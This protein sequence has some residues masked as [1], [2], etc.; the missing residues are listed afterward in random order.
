MIQLMKK[1]KKRKKSVIKQIGEQIEK[2]SLNY[3]KRMEKK[4]R[5]Y[6]MKLLSTMIRT[7]KLNIKIF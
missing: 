2:G 5:K 4:W 1:R 7:E 3:K 6:I